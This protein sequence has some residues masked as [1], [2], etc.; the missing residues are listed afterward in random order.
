VDREVGLKIKSKQGFTFLQILS[1]YPLDHMKTSASCVNGSVNDSTIPMPAFVVFGERMAPL[2]PL[3]LLLVLSS[4]AV[5]V[6]LVVVV[7]AVIIT[8]NSLPRSRSVE[9]S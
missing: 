2:S 5:L 6:L 4:R 7:I 1:E 3:I 9:R 8:I